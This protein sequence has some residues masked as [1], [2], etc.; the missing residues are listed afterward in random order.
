MKSLHYSVDDALERLFEVTGVLTDAM[1]HVLGESALTPAR[2]EI[3]W[4]IGRQG[5]MTQRQ[6][7]A[8]LRCTPRNV[9]GLV[10]AL[11]GMGL[12]TREP[13]PTD[14]RATLV[15]LTDQGGETAR[16]WGAGYRQLARHLFGDL[17]A[18][19]LANAIA[20]LEHILER[21]RDPATD[22]I[23]ADNVVGREPSGPEAQ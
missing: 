4:R 10:D 12:V 6:L 3:I 15:T 21:L 14:R 2:A 22:R 1:S 17:D 13:H 11:E 8:A 7:S 5:P 18:G 19:A 9:T 23:R 16:D 20:A